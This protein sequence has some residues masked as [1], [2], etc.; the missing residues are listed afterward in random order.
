[1]LEAGADRQL[2]AD[3]VRGMQAELLFGL[4]YLLEDPGVSAEDDAG[5]GWRLVKTDENGTPSDIPIACVHQSVLETDPT[6]REMRP[7]ECR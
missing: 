3:L 1:L 2:L 6:G 4:C 7:R 5:I